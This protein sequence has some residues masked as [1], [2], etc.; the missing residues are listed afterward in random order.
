MFMRN[1]LLIL[2]LNVA[3]VSRQVYVEFMCGTF[4][5]IYSK[6]VAMDFVPFANEVIYFLVFSQFRADSV[7]GFSLLAFYRLS[8]LKKN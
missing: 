8:R 5:P 6:T 4:L 2:L 7:P 1:V 3:E